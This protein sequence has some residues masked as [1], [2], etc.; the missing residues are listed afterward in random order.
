MIMGRAP[1]ARRVASLGLATFVLLVAPLLTFTPTSS[2]ADVTSSTLCLGYAGCSK[3]AFSAH[4]YQAH[5]GTEYWRMYAGNNCT[6]YVAY[7]ESTTYAI[8]TPANLL[9]NADQWPT[10]APLDGALVNHTP[11]V[12]SV[13]EWNPGSPG[14][15]YPGHVAI[16]EQVGPH[17]S[18]I[19][20]SQQGMI[21]G[22]GFDWTRINA[23]SATNQW[24]QWPSNF[25]HFPTGVRSA[26][27]ASALA[28]VHIMVRRAPSHLATTP[29]TAKSTAPIARHHVVTRVAR[30]ARLTP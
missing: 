19:V 30:T 21:D 26:Q 24:Q 3:G 5:S 16:V 8:T 18:Y 25:I 28:L 2:A 27:R 15:P 17:Q 22:S 1:H 4:G 6:N 20:I 12:G 23:D 13:A 10:T 7:V 9:G 14:I 29:R 11:T